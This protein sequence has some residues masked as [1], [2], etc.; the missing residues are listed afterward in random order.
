MEVRTAGSF[1][2]FQTYIRTLIIS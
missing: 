1:Y 2:S